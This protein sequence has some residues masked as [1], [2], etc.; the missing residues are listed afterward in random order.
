MT[1]EEILKVLNPEQQKAVQ[2][3]NGPVLVLA[4]AGTGKTRVITYRIAYMLSSGIKPQSILGLTFTNKA[5]REMRERLAS[6]VDPDSAS[7][8]TLG[9]F[10]AFCVKV[11]RQDIRHLGYL[12]GFTIADTTDQQGLFKQAVAQLGWSKDECSLGVLTARIGSWKNQLLTPQDA[13]QIAE[14]D[15]DVM[16]SALYFTYQELL[17]LQNMVDFDDMI[18]LVYRLFSEFPEILQRYQERYQYLLVDEYQDTNAAQFKVIKMLAGERCNLCVV[19]D[20][21]QSIYGWRGAEIEN[22]LDFPNLFP[23]TCEIKLEQNYRSTNKILNAANAVIRT[24]TA[25]HDKQLWSKLG[26]GADLIAVN[27]ENGEKESEFIAS[28][29]RQKMGE[30]P[31]LSYQD[32]AILYRS[33]HLS[34]ELENG[35]RQAEIPYTLVGGQE[36]YNRKEIKDAVAYL[37][38]VVN[39]RDNQSFLRILGTPPRGLAQKAVEILK[40]MYL[41]QKTPMLRLIEKDEFLNA[42][43]GKGAAA[44]KEL[45][46]A[47]AHAREVFTVPGNLA[48]KISSF[49]REVGFLDGMQKMYKDID[50]ARSRRE[51]VDEFISAISQYENKCSEPPSLEAYLESFSLLE[52]NDRTEEKKEPG[53]TLSTVHASK[54]LEY[55]VVFLV[56]MEKDS[57]PHERSLEE[58]SLDEEKRLFYVA[59]TRAKKELF[60]TCSRERYVKGQRKSRIESPFLHLLPSDSLQTGQ[61]DDFIKTLSKD[62]MKAAFAKIFSILDK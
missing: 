25:R 52:E 16:A 21:D 61:P 62:D 18:M 56:A 47:F 8:V 50:D 57:F 28:M 55:P 13:R 58:G 10:H 41:A 4:G 33:N 36:F 11:L 9:T 51:N 24:N 49:L 40:E 30:N 12:P 43:S 3:V 26:D 2:T 59:I 17:E 54:G 23:G 45:T 35:L 6:L 20:D 44:A 29:I 15:I 1:C 39:E 22:I 31:E 38:L 27:A 19:G 42:V 32:F 53:V 14:T 37:K 60:L 48:G 46:A 34:R 5:A 7:K